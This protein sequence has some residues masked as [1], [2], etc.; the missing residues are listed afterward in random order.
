M[1]KTGQK[2]LK[3]SLLYSF[4]MHSGGE[5]QGASEISTGTWGNQMCYPSKGE[6]WTEN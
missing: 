2:I 1:G 5:M 3:G 4:G 6:I